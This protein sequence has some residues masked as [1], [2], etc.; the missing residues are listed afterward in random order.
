MNNVR[1]EKLVSGFEEERRKIRQKKWKEYSRHGDRH[2][3]FFRAADLQG[4]PAEDSLK[5]MMTK[6]VIS[7]YDML[8]DLKDDVH[9]SL[10]TWKGKAFDLQNYI[11]LL[12]TMLAE[13]YGEALTEDEDLG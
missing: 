8:D 4:G 12:L 11:D 1:F 3:N 10:A 5:G 13:R 6:H 9:H 7:I 2:H